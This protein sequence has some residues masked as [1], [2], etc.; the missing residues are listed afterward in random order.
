MNETQIN[1][2]ADFL[3]KKSKKAGA[4]SV[5]VLY[6]ENTN[7]DVGSRLKKIEKLERSETLLGPNEDV[8]ESWDEAEDAFMSFDRSTFISEEDEEI[9]ETSKSIFNNF[10][11]SQGKYKKTDSYSFSEE[12]LK[13]IVSN[14]VKKA[15]EK[16]IASSL[17]ELAVS[18]LKNKVNQ[19]D[20]DWA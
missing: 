17:V 13:E 11:D 10:E 4:D 18:E 7:I 6:V 20:Q 3:I 14:S 12:E 19:M 15:L 2:K 9:P 16:S 8:F 1:E 5:D